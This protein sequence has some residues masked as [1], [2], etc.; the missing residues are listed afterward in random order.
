M[1]ATQYPVILT[2][3]SISEGDSPLKIS[4]SLFAEQVEWLQSNAHVTS[5]AEVVSALVEGKPMRERT[6]VLTFDDGFRDFYSSAAPILRRFKLPGTIFLATGYCGGMSSWPGQPDGM[7][8]EPLLNPR[9][10]SELAHEG[11]WFGAH[12]IGHP[13]LAALSATKAEAEIV[14]SKLRIHEL[15]G[16]T[17]EFFAY[18][19]GRWS[20]S[21]RNLVAKHYRGACATSAGVVEPDADPYALPRV[22]AHYVRDRS[23]FRRLF[24]GPFLT[25]LVTRRLI[26]RLRGQPEGSYAR[27]RDSARRS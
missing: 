6:V 2:Y 18:P 10:V 8:K 15:T 1:N 25:Y 27:V 11:F 22:D 21:V 26:R 7:C 16:Q 3:H 17:A 4:P 13:N 23:W 9:E 24:T 14:G 20:L 12:S 5:L 19:F